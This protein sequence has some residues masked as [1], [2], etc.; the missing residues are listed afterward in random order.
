MI[1]EGNI[2]TFGARVTAVSRCDTT[3]NCREGCTDVSPG[4]NDCYAETRDGRHLTG[5]VNRRKEYQ[6][7]RK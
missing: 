6:R 1:T 4:R 7:W 5:P 2:E 3:F